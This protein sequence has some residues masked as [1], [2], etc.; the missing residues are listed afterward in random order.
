MSAR[1]R[2]RA[3]LYAAAEYYAW[4]ARR[5]HYPCGNDPSTGLEWGKFGGPLQRIGRDIGR[6][7]NT[8]AARV[9]YAAARRYPSPLPG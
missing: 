2:E 4:S 3:Q 8:A 5:Q 6:A 9:A 1:N 7:E